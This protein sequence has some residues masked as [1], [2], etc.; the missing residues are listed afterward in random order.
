MWSM[1]WRWAP[2]LLKTACHTD[3]PCGRGEVRYGRA[4]R[5]ILKLISWTGIPWHPT[6]PWNC[7]AIKIH[8]LCRL[9]EGYDLVVVPENATFV[10][11]EPEEKKETSWTRRVL[12]W[13]QHKLSN[14][15]IPQSQER[16]TLTSSYSF[17]KIIV[18]IVQLLYAISTLYEVRGDQIARYGYAA[19]G[20]TVAPYAWMSLVNLVGNLMCPQYD[21]MYVV[22]TS[23]L[24]TLCESQCDRQHFFVDG[25]VGQLTPDTDKSLKERHAETRAFNALKLM[26]GIH[27]GRMPLWTR[28]FGTT[29]QA[30][31][32]EEK[33]DS[34]SI[35]RKYIQMYSQHIWRLCEGCFVTRPDFYSL[36]IFTL[37]PIAIVGALSRFA[38][39]DSLL[40]Q[41]VWTM[42]WL[43]GGS[44]GGALL[45]IILNLPGED[46]LESVALIL[47]LG[48]YYCATAIG[49]Y[50]VVG[51][52]IAEY[53]TC[54]D[55]S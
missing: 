19:F 26:G 44:V 36:A 10:N 39:G 50:V 37:P 7:N 15:V 13:I 31:L 18:S 54:T 34:T 30:I 53:G 38:A 8:G 35:A 40:Y 51:Q 42:M 4:S 47:G 43:V 25:T 14:P 22:V 45:G 6:E 46:V 16:F 32:A 3:P 28:K 52:M 2:A 21:A 24:I 23:D 41:R 17:V 9:P 48:I 33:K 55:I 11:D 5:T 20:L 29:S 12:R 1:I 27:D 49:G